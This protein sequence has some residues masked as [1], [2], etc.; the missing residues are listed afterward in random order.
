MV[1]YL[2]IK[3]LT[4]RF[5]R[6]LANDSVS[7]SV[8]KSEVRALLGENGAGKSTLMSCLYGLYGMDSGEFL[9]D[10][11]KVYIGNCQDAIRLGIGMVNQHFMLVQK[12][13]VTENVIL[14]LKDEK[15]PWVD[16][17]GAARKIQELSDKYNFCI[18]PHAMI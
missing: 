7:L 6:V 3:D 8:E 10:G 14:G 11:K 5:S 1:P 18:N 12:L 2:E 15:G 9:I 16:Y 13:T 4:K 17:Q